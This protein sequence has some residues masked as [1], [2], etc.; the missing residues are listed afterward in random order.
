MNVM[1]QDAMNDKIIKKMQNMWKTMHVR[2]SRQI[3]RCREA[4]EQTWDFSI[5]PPNYRE[6]SRLR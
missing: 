5:D 1:K 4:I 3:E 6:V 2:G